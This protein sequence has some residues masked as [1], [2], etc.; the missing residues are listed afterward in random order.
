MHERR[1]LCKRSNLKKIIKTSSSSSTILDIERFPSLD[2]GLPGSL[3]QL[4]SV[5]I[6]L[7]D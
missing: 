2:N 1:I 7:F 4:V 5:S 6:E 3:F